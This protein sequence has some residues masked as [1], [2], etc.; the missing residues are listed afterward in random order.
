MTNHVVE[1]NLL[2][3]KEEIVPYTPRIIAVTK[4]YDINAIL[5]A[6][7]A[8]LRDFGESRAN[9]AISKIDALPDEIRKES[10]FH[11]IG[12]LQT[13]KVDK[14]VKHFD[15]IQ[16]VDSLRLAKAISQSADKLN[17]VQK[18][19]IQV[20]ISGEV[21][22]FGFDENELRNC[23]YELKGLVGISVEGLMCMAPLGADDDELDRV[24]SKAANL[25]RELNEKY[26]LSLKELSMGM[27]D[28]YKRAVANGATMIRVGRLLFN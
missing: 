21:Q 12:H 1:T 8:G 25:L 27:S 4:Y 20:N 14:V 18:I 2:R 28:D 15:Y 16:S 7:S 11:F 22:K 5:E 23:I 13:N 26:G 24:F 9:D 6:Y 10:F 17:K 3:L 19:L